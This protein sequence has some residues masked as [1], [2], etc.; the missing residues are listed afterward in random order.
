MIKQFLSIATMLF[1]ALSVTGC[2]QYESGD[3][4]N[5]DSIALENNITEGRFESQEQGRIMVSEINRLWFT[6]LEEFLYATASARDARGFWDLHIASRT[7]DIRLLSSLDTFYLPAN[8]PNGFYLHRISVHGAFIDIF[9]M[10]FYGEVTWEISHEAFSNNRYFHL[11]FTRWTYED[12]E[13]WGSNTPLDGIMRQ[14]GFRENDFIDGRYL[15]HESTNTLYWAQG[16]NR[17]SLQM[18]KD[19]PHENNNVSEFAAEEGGLPAEPTV[20]DM[21]HFANT[22]TLD[23]QNQAN[24]AAW[25]AGD[26]TMVEELLES[27]R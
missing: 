11:Q 12:L 23:L 24:I 25:S 15:F 14:F 16:S 18:P 9:Y 6:S 10:P 26:F 2:T 5:L 1:V 3:A 4:T 27:S 7:N 13:S 19:L 17:F 21:L 22:V 20:Y 8:I